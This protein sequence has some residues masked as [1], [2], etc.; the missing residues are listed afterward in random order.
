MA[1]LLVRGS[2]GL[3]C[4]GTMGLGLIGSL[5]GG[6]LANLLLVGDLRLAPSGFIGSVVGAVVVLA[7]ARLFSR[8]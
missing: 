4:A 2:G 3:G 8:R 1:R 7:L 5:V 6:T